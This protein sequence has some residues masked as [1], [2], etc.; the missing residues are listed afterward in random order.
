MTNIL[1]CGR[2]VPRGKYMPKELSVRHYKC[3]S[4]KSTNHMT[5]EF[6]FLPFNIDRSK[7]I[8]LANGVKI[9]MED[10]EL[11]V[12]DPNEGKWALCSILVHPRIYWTCRPFATYP[13]DLCDK[14]FMESIST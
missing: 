5:W 7:L 14:D 11:I 3:D 12:E 8:E 10:G 6:P 2:T 13:K 1:L 9:Y 4:C